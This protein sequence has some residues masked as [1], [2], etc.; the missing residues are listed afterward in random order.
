MKLNKIFVFA[1]IT[2]LAISNT[3]GGVSSAEIFE[4]KAP[5]TFNNRFQ[6]DNNTFFSSNYNMGYIDL[7]IHNPGE[8]SKWLKL[9]YPLFLKI[10]SVGGWQKEPLLNNLQLYLKKDIAVLAHTYPGFNNQYEA[11]EVYIFK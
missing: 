2:I 5:V 4:I 9:N 1:L 6:F 7:V 11:D 3:L 8:D 10:D